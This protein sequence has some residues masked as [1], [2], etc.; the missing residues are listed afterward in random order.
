[1]PI[2]EAMACGCPVITSRNGSIEEVAGDAA[3]YIDPEDASTMTAALKKLQGKPYRTRFVTAGLKRAHLYS[4]RKMAGIVQAALLAA[5]ENAEPVAAQPVLPTREQQLALALQH[6]QAGQLD[7]AEK[8]YLQLLS[9]NANDFVALHLLGVARHQQGNF[10]EAT[11]LLEKAIGINQ[12]TPEAHYNLGNTYLAQERLTE[13]LAC[14]RRALELNPQFS[15]ARNRLAE[16]GV[17]H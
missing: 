8:T 11:R 4:W 7:Q 2:I 1:M 5:A 17:A 3:I 13:A 14:F 16:L 12:L 15:L 9:T 6:H 10:A